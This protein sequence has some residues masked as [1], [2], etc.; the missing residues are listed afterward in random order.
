MEKGVKKATIIPSKDIILK[1]TSRRELWV[2]KK[3]I[4]SMNIMESLTLQTSL[5]DKVYSN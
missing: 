3:E 4:F 1:D 5:R 2:G